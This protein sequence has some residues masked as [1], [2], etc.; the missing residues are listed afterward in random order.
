MDADK[1]LKTLKQTR[2]RKLGTLTRTRRRA[3]ILIEA[4][5]SRTELTKILKELDL[6]FEAVQ[7]AHDSFV[8]QLT[9]EEDVKTAVKYI[10]DVEKQYSDAVERISEHL[11][12]RKDE[13]P[14]VASAVGQVAANS[15][16]SER[17]EVAKA[18]EAEIQERIKEM[19]FSQMKKQLEIEQQE[20]ELKRKRMLQEAADARSRAALEASLQKA[21]LDDLQWERRN[22]FPDLTEQDVHAPMAHHDQGKE[23]LMTGTV[24]EPEDKASSRRCCSASNRNTPKV[25]LPQFSGNSLEWPQWFG[26]FCALVDSRDGLSDTE[27]MVHL[28]A[29][30]IGLA[31]KTIAGFMYSPHLYRDA[32]MVLQERFG[33]QKDIVRAHL[34]TLFG[35]PRIGVSSAAALEELYTKVNCT[36]TVLQSLHCDGDLMS[37]ENLQRMVEKL[38]AD[39]R[40]EWSRHE[41]ESELS[42]PSL[43]TFS[44]WLGGQVKIALNCIDPVSHVL[45]RRTSSKRATLLTSTDHTACVCCD[46]THHLAD[47]SIFAGWS[48]GNRA[49]FV[50]DRG[51]CFVCLQHGHLIRTCRWAKPCGEEGC[52]MRHHELLHG[53]SRVFRRQWPVEEAR[54]QDHVVKRQTS[55]NDAQAP[56]QV[57]TSV[58]RTVATSFPVDESETL[59]QIVPV[60]IHGEGSTF[61]DVFALLDP[62]SQ[63]SLCAADVLTSLNITGTPSD[64]C[65]Q[66]VEGSGSPQSSQKVKLLVSPRSGDQV[67]IEVSE[68][69]S[70]PRLN[71]K[72]P[73]IS[74][75]QRCRWEHTLDLDI[76]DYRGVEIKLLLGA[77]VIEAVIQ[78]E[79]R[80]GRPGQPVAVR[81]AFGWT[82]TGTVKGLVPGPLRHVMF[83][84]KAPVEHD[85][86]SAIE[87]WW[88][89]ESFG[90]KIH[91]PLA[92]S[93]EED[94]A[95]KIMGASVGGVQMGWHFLSLIW[96]RGFPNLRDPVSHKSVEAPALVVQILQDN[97]AVTPKH[98]PMYLVSQF[99]H[100]GF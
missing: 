78:Q 64:L 96:I 5:G 51:L 55:A 70:V 43:A 97:D 93:V 6:T 59:L 71:V 95:E 13:A 62:G 42:S 91:Q 98:S 83:I 48:V 88:K 40:R 23:A 19:E 52:T 46:G 82:L 17:S 31:K 58:H 7:E 79:V 10:E 68:A 28:Q 35:A 16:V 50:A 26:L 30:V 81:T 76:P 44:K 80:I 72:P 36:V 15:A 92:R 27:K 33:R 1:Q 22:D 49:Q 84:R 53:S 21:A 65:L 29:S 77:N 32:L 14:S 57:E 87:D 86:T 39:L 3:F 75:N 73:Q 2:A 90:V 54:Q 63:T 69:F 99:L 9:Q 25:T 12:A 45:E 56:T 8:D 38:P 89:T 94:R 20:Q 34:S 66:N 67:P 74:A 37:H 11:E 61:E 60:R 47:C 4:K 41:I 24:L 18:R 85:L 100:D